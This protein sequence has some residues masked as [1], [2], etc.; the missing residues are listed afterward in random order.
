MRRVSVPV[1]VAL[2]LGGASV[3]FLVE[4]MFAATGRRVIVPPW[5]LPV[6]LVVAGAV[7]LLLAWPIRRAV[8]AGTLRRVNPFQAT[9]VAAFAKACA[10]CGALL[11]GVGGGI[12]IYL[13]TRTVVGSFSSVVLAVATMVAGA[14]LLVAGLIAEHFCMLP[15]DEPNPEQKDAACV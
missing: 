9:R 5:S 7:V 4:F 2:A 6:T 14:V 12:T 8:V 15:P 1:L 11:S 13:L 10:L 3:G